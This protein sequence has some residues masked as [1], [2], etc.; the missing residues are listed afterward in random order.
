MSGATLQRGDEAELGQLALGLLRGDGGAPLV[1]T[2]GALYRYEGAS[3]IWRPVDD[4]AAGLVVQRLAGSPVGEQGK[5]LRLSDGQIRGAVRCAQRAAA[6]PGFFD[7]QP[8]GVAFKNG[9][10]TVDETGRID[11]LP[12]APAHRATFTLPCNYH[13]AERAGSWGRFLSS[14][15][16]SAEDAAD[17]V[18]FLAQFVGACLLGQATR[19]QRFALLHGP[20]GTGKSTFLEIVGALFP[21]Q[22]VAALPPQS[23]DHEYSRAALA[24]ARLNLVSELPERDLLDTAATKAAVVG[25]AMRGRDP[26]GQGFTFRPTA[27]HLWAANS[28]PQVYDASGAW[29]RRVVVVPFTDPPEAPDRTLA[30]RVIASELAAVACWA[31]D[32]AADLARGG[33]RIPPSSVRAVDAWRYQGD[34]VFQW[35]SECCRVTG[36]DY[37]TSGAEAYRAF[38]DW[39]RKNGHHPVASNKWAARLQLHGVRH[40]RTARESLW[41]LQVIDRD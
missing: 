30:Q 39:A 26:Y 36:G 19:Y 11:L 29:W 37:E 27:G 9:F 16:R 28:L 41:S 17:R 25:D 14:A 34:L 38:A 20:G 6:D 5:P 23:L 10:A 7:A 35:L 40:Q 33:Y 21:A 32:G 24:R 22:V 31:L 13:G 15:F 3:G 8:P 1:F 2:R 4:T 12:H 18:R